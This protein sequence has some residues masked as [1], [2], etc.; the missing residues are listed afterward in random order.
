MLYVFRAPSRLFVS[1]TV[2]QVKDGRNPILIQEKPMHGKRFPASEAHRLDNPDR[3][4]WLPPDQVLAMLAVR[5]G[6]VVADVGA[7][8]GYFTLPI[9]RAVSPGG[10]VWAV[11]AQEGMLAILQRKLEETS[12]LNVSL[13]H[14]EADRTGLPASTIDLFLLANLWHEIEDHAAVLREVK[15][16]VRPGG[17]LAILDWRTDVAPE[18][19]P[20]MEH[21]LSGTTTLAS[22][23]GEGFE[24][25]T[26][27]TVGLYSWL[28][29]GEFNP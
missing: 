2:F 3:L 9:A 27:R 14:A 13:V 22:L 21:R 12:V 20:P 15:R 25:A 6:E 18:P 4:Q 24:R 7:G 28:V 17:R 5:A 8:T 1:D 26:V 29:Q 16:V 10:S 19:G 23:I 11:D